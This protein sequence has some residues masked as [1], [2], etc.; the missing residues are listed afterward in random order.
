MIVMDDIVRKNRTRSTSLKVIIFVG[1]VVTCVLINA[2]GAYLANSSGLPIY[3][4]LVGTFLAAILGG[5]LPGILYPGPKENATGE[6]LCARTHAS[7]KNAGC[8]AEKTSGPRPGTRALPPPRRQR[9]SCRG[10]TPGRQ[11]VRGA[12]HLSS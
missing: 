12:L 11:G 8:H 7:R 10:K 9:K 3:F 4:D 6:S 5:F 1:L 2:L